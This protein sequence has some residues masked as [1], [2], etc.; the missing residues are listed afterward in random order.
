[1]NY[2]CN[3]KAEQEINLLTA[4]E[5]DTIPMC[6]ICLF[7]IKEGKFICTDCQV[8]ICGYHVNFHNKHKL[9]ELKLIE[10]I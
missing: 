6:N 5:V 10:K 9:I 2:I 3:T 1:M 7:E 4:I 8:N